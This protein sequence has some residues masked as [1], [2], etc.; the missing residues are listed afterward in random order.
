MPPCT[1]YE[2][3]LTTSVREEYIWCRY[4]QHQIYTIVSWP[5]IG[6]WWSAATSAVIIC[7]PHCQRRCRQS[8]R[9]K[10]NA[11]VRSSIIVFRAPVSDLLQT[12]TAAKYILASHAETWVRIQYGASANEPWVR[13]LRR[14]ACV[15]YPCD[16]SFPNVSWLISTSDGVFHLFIM[17]IVL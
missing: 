1:V 14:S 4:D 16:I 7:D 3:D 10:W 15:H 8:S 12:A 9:R 11:D 6:C 13:S 2:P 17:Q 5:L